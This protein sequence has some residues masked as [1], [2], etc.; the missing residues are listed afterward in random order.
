MVLGRSYSRSFSANQSKMN[1]QMANDND[2][3][4][5]FFLVVNR[6]LRSVP[7]PSHWIVSVCLLK[8][9]RRRRWSFVRPLYV[10]KVH[11]NR[12]S[13]NKK[14]YLVRYYCRI[15]C[16][17]VRRPKLDHTIIGYETAAAVANSNDIR[18]VQSVESRMS[19]QHSLFLL[20]STL[21]SS[22]L[23]SDSH[24]P[25]LMDF[26]IYV[27]QNRKTVRTKKKREREGTTSRMWFEFFE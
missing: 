26:I 14:G 8:S 1:K 18:P 25:W 10:L 22:S 11:K 15:E 27:S 16:R 12:W 20:P 9:S 21:V 24:F 7:V 5:F 17:G 2:R 19:A 4:R 23:R 13:A 6:L 3:M